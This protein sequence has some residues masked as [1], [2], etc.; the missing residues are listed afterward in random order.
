[1]AQALRALDLVA[2]NYLA[3]DAVVG[4]MLASVL[5]AVFWTFVVAGTGEALGWHLHRLVLPSI[6]VGVAVFLFLVIAAL[7]TRLSPA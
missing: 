5:P 6:T 3:S 4:A 1:M 2:R 7:R